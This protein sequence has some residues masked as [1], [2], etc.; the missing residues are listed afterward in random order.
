M[1]DFDTLVFFADP[2]TA[3][4]FGLTELG[5]GAD[6]ISKGINPAGRKHDLLN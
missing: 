4:W 2:C 3:V 6:L 5:Y 1:F